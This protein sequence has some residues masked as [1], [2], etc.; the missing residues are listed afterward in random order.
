MSSSCLS[1]DKIN[2]YE[3]SQ[4]ID[5]FTD[6]PL[7]LPQS[8]IGA[9][10]LLFPSNFLY[11]YLHMVLL[12]T[13]FRIFTYIIDNLLYLRLGPITFLD[14]KRKYIKVVFLSIL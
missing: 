7:L 12:Y 3:M 8:Q 9:V 13:L 4:D 6:I 2:W 10:Y 5:L 14:N 1:W 11:L